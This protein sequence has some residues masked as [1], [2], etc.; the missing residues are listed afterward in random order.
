[1]NNPKL[2][3]AAR[4]QIEM[5]MLSLDQMLPADHVVREIWAYVERMDLSGITGK[6]VSVQGLAGAPAFDPRTLMCL[7]IFATVEAVGSARRLSRLV[8]E[9]LPYRWIAGGEPVNYHTLSD[10]RIRHGEALDRLLTASVAL[11]ADEGWLDLSAMTV[12]HDGMR[13]RASAG[14]DSM[15]RRATLERHLKSARERV[16][17]LKAQTH[18][19]DEPPRTRSKSEAAQ[20]RAAREH[21]ERLERALEAMDELESK[22]RTRSDRKPREPRAS[23]TDPEARMLRMA[24]G[25]KDPA[26]NI[27][28]TAETGAR[29]IVSVTVSE[30]SS[31]TGQ[32]LPAMRA[33]Q[34]RHGFLPAKVLA[35]QGYFKYSDIAELERGGCQVL[36]NDLYPESENHGHVARDDRASIE[37]W[38]E[39]MQGEA[40]QQEYKLRPSTVEWSNAC[41]RQHGL[42]QLTVRGRAKVR[43]VGLLHA[44]THNIARTLSL[45]RQLA[46]A[47]A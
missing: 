37:R 27:Q 34:A 12:A 13:V 5:Q 41:V 44:L 33:H 19:P 21:S 42:Q 6:V 40:A 46:E 4:D 8:G 47:M 20:Q 28:F 36:M 35:D 9:S 11:L 7:W 3:Y 16:E 24:N 14:R 10:F 39:R 1:M 38:R 2:R 17:Q 31:D 45:R 30:G 18:D 15:H 25:G 43:I 26:H 29:A 22:Q 32:L 23:E